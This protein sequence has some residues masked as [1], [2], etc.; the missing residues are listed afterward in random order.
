M[1]ESL[2]GKII[3]KSATHLVLDVGGVGYGVDVSLRT[4]AALEIGESTQRINTY[5]NVRED[6]L[7]LFGFI[8]ESERQ[9]FL[10]LIS[11]SGIGPRV[12]LRILSEVS[13]QELVDFIV[14]G[15]VQRLT[16]LKGIG[17]KTAEV[18]IA[19]LKGPL[20]KLE[21]KTSAAGTSVPLANDNVSDAIQA[22]MALGVKEKQAQMAVQKAV[23]K[24]GADSTSSELISTALKLV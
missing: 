12:A 13:P 22:L 24:L 2:Q 10:K 1:I 7:E 15:Q 17:K 19:S 3:S 11:V 18:M 5:L 23:D 9:V 16:S 21:W 6:A 4:S 20:S 8:E 14:N